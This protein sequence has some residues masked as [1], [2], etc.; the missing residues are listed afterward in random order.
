MKGLYF[1]VALLAAAVIILAVRLA[2]SDNAAK[3]SAA[4]SA[5]A[6][7]YESV[8]T[9]TSVRQYADRAVPDSICEKILRAGMAAPS[10]VN[11]QPWHFF[12]I[13]SRAMKDAVASKF[14]NASMTAKAPLTIVVCGNLDLA[15]KDEG[16]AYWIQDCSAATENMLVAAN[17]LGLGGVWCG[18]YPIAERVELLRALLHL[19]DNL[20][21]LNVVNFG[22]PAAPQAPKDKWAPSKISHI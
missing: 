22:Y 12:V 17:A 15:M 13:D 9:R 5:V 10:A 16:V 4:N 11:A 21:P 7:G 19:P 1:I 2:Q 3:D 8:M 6:D 14:R 20:V 18:I